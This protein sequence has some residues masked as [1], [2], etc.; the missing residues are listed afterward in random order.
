MPPNELY[1]FSVVSA[2]MDGVAST[3]VP[4]R[5][6]LAHG[7]HGLGTFRS[8]RGELIA[9]DGECWQMRH[10]GSVR[11]ADLTEGSPTEDFSP[12]AMVTDFA[13]E[14]S[15]RAAISAK[16]GVEGVLARL[17]P[18]ANNTHVAFRIDGAFKAIT[19]RTAQGQCFP[20]EGLKDVASRQV[21][22]TL[23]ASRGTV[24]GFRSPQFLQGVAVAGVHMHYI[25][26]GRTAGGHVL[27]LESDGEVEVQVAELWRTV[28]DLPRGDAAF[29]AAPLA[30]NDGGIKAVEG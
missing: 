3:G 26:E 29:N 9:L 12:F 14:A 16:D 24:V 1:Q 6:V 25:D 21:T 27:A 10:D 30:L 17:A 18:N 23:P 13:A 28:M 11:A 22:V 8:M 19:V 7:S 5:Q 4:L 2:L 20:G 15:T